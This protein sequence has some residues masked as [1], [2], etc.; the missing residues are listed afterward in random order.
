MPGCGNVVDE[1]RAAFGSKKACQSKAKKPEPKKPAAS[2]TNTDEWEKWC[3]TEAQK[4]Y[5]D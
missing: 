3:E 2:S 1:A 5:F 4:F